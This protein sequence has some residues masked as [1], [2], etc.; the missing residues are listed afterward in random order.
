MLPAPFTLGLIATVCLAAAS[1]SYGQLQQASIAV[2]VLDL[3]RQPLARTVIVLTDPL[4]SEV[5]TTTTAANGRAT[6]EGVAQGRYELHPVLPGAPPMFVPVHVT[7]ALPLEVTIRVPLGLSDTVMVEGTAGDEPSARGSRSALSLAALPVR[8]RGRALQDAIA[9]FPGWST[10]DNG[11]L[12]ARGVDDGFLYVIDGVPV[13]ERL[14]ALSGVAPDLLSVATVNVV[15]GYVPPE[16]GYKAGGVIEVRSSG[17]QSWNGTL[18]TSGGSD[19]T[20]DFAAALGGGLA[21]RGGIRASASAA[22]SDRFL[23]PVHP[24]NLHNQ[25]DLSQTSLQF[26]WGIPNTDRLS[27]GWGHGR[28]RFDVP[29][30]EEQD[31]AGQDQR[32]RLGQWFLNASWQ[33]IWS[34]RFVSQAGGYHRRTRSRLDGS[35]MDT[36]IEASADRALNRTGVIVAMTGQ[37]KRH[38]LKAGGE[39]QRLQLDEQFWFAIT[40]E[41][42]AEEAGFRDDTLRFTSDRP[43]QFRDAA[44]PALYSAYV[45]DTWRIAQRVTVSGGLRLDRM[46]LLLPRVQVSPR[47]GAALR[48]SDRTLVRG[49]VNRFAQPPQPENLLLSSS[50]QA[51]ELSPFAIGGVAGGADLEPERQWAIEASLEQQLGRAR[52]DIAY[53]TRR[54]RNVADPNV[55]AGTTIIF[56]NSVDKG[57]AHGVEMHVQLPRHRGWS[58]YANW[59]VARVVQTG[60]INGGLFLEDEVE[61]IGPG[62][63]FSPDHDQR[64]TASGGVSWDHPSGV[65]VAL[66]ARHETGTPVQREED[67]LEELLGQPGAE[68]VDFGAGRVKPRTVVS[69]RL[70]VP[71]VDRTRIRTAIGLQVLNAFDARYAFNFGNPFSG[72]HF[73]APRT[74][75]INVRMTFR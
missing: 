46:R 45:Q 19:A 23:D 42:E 58:G 68:M 3:Q 12:H 52:L 48:L 72:T 11:L 69:A 24:D 64:F 14:D 26:E 75:S 36:P 40:D 47:L 2:V 61:E 65:G 31:E 35:A 5:Q 27:A 60:P 53:W 59:A 34:A 70:L 1:P 67:E 57:R 66:V 51:R 62:V 8:V 30:N 15:T 6:F 43:F 7:G 10:E 17:A 37:Y 63:E 16:F 38:T 41:D 21:G 54:M 74:V 73:G 44:H 28:S 13:Y 55:F 20:R 56:P 33:R 25:G 4:G 18:D 29:N 39:W 49:V 32:Q 22:A 9:T 71:I 50:P